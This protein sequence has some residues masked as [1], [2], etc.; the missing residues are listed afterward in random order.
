MRRKAKTGLKRLEK[1]G[2][3]LWGKVAVLRTDWAH[4]HQELAVQAPIGCI[5][6]KS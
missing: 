6:T 4:S 3:F 1:S 2:L 5:R